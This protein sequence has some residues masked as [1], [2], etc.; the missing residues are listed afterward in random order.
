[1]NS[2]LPIPE[3]LSAQLS[4]SLE[5]VCCECSRPPGKTRAG[6]PEGLL[7]CRVSHLSHYFCIKRDADVF[8]KKRCGVLR[9]MQTRG[10]LIRKYFY[11]VNL[12]CEVSSCKQGIAGSSPDSWGEVHSVS[13]AVTD[14]LG[15]KKY[16]QS[17]D[18]SSNGFSS[19][20]VTRVH[21]IFPL[22]FVGY[23]VCKLPFSFSV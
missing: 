17:L 7:S 3:G 21:S 13:S 12:N 19:V 8:K 6:F 20:C 11:F 16:F 15:E 2:A 22:T 10:L 9:E 14:T 1:M 18:R 5:V 23:G 4:Q